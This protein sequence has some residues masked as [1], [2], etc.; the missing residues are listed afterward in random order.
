MRTRFAF[1]APVLCSVLFPLEL[2]AGLEEG[3]PRLFGVQA[4][5]ISPQHAGPA[6]AAQGTGGL[7]V[8]PAPAE[9]IRNTLGPL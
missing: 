1:P 8:A 6:S 3:D 5:S 7:L 9:G 4:S 2:H